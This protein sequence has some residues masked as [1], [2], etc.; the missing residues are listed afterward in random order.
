[1]GKNPHL[2]S[3]RLLCVLGIGGRGRVHIE[4]RKEVRSASGEV[5]KA[6]LKAHIRS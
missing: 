2:F 6:A 4:V 3:I 5:W 1:M